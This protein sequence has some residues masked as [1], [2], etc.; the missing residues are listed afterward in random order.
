MRPIDNNGDH[1]LDS[2]ILRSLA[3]SRL[4]AEAVV[5]YEI[6][7]EDGTRHSYE[8]SAGEVEA[9]LNRVDNRESQTGGRRMR[10]GRPTRWSDADLARIVKVYTEAWR[11]GTYPLKAIEE[12]MGITRAEASKAVTRARLL[13]WLGKTPKG[14]AGGVL[15]SGP[16][17]ARGSK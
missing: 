1:I 14:K 8:G 4:L 6:E 11:Q 15:D 5:G 2:T 7:Y 3:P 13:G 9:H 16:L 12:N 10:R 17:P